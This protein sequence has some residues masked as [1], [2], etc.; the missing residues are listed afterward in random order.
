MNTDMRAWFDYSE[1]VLE[2]ANLFRRALNFRLVSESIVLTR[3]RL[4]WSEIR[5]F[6]AAN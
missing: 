2:A 6:S 1:L 3:N 4:N 5:M